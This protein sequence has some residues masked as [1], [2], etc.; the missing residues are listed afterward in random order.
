L[1]PFIV[2]NFNSELEEQFYRQFYLGQSP[3]KTNNTLPSSFLEV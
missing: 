1:D 2:K 3:N